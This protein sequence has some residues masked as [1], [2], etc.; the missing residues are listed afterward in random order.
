MFVVDSG[1]TGYIIDKKRLQQIREKYG[2][3]YPD[4]LGKEQYR[5]YQSESIV[6]KLYRN[7]LNYIHGKTDEIENIFAQLNID[8]QQIIPNYRTSVRKK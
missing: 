1:K 8:D 5:S 4:F 2:K 6:G 3:K 7:A